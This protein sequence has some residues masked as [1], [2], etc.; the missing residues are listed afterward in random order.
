VH[1]RSG[2]VT[3]QHGQNVREA[4]FVVLDFETVT[5]KGRPPEPL[6]LAALRIGIGLEVDKRFRFDSLIKPPADAPIT[7]FDTAQTGIRPSDV[8]A[9]ATAASVMRDFDQ[10]VR[11]HPGILVAHNAS[12]EANILSRYPEDCPYVATLPIIDT[13]ALARHVL[14]G[15][16]NYKLDALARRFD[17]PIPTERHR[18]LPDVELTVRVF[19]KLLD[20]PRS[21]QTIKEL[22]RV[23]GI[24]PPEP[25]LQAS[26]FG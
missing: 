17:I 24:I 21:P 18:A 14:P 1:K 7:E 19:I 23:A 10:L 16:F 6:E 5:P 20:D 4:T 9:S 2:N 15:L 13:V 25:D 22:R 26:L 12:Y 3:L 8:E 11:E